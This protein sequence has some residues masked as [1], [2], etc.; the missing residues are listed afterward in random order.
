[1]TATNE[2]ESPKGATLKGDRVMI[3]DQCSNYVE[4][5]FKTFG[6]GKTVKVK[7]PIELNGRVILYTGVFSIEYVIEN[8]DGKVEDVLSRTVMIEPVNRC[9][10]DD[11]KNGCF[12]GCV[13]NSVC[14]PD[15]DTPAGFTCQL[16]R[17]SKEIE[18]EDITTDEIGMRQCDKFDKKNT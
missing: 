11:P 13:G 16:R 4:P 7:M 6:G 5:G 1:M 18:G 3:L 9:D 14:V 2:T 8:E 10:I 12:H 15:A 17:P